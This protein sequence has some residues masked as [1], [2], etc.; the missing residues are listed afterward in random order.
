MQSSSRP[1][2]SSPSSTQAARCPPSRPRSDPKPLVVLAGET[3][4]GGKQNRIINVTVWL[5]AKKLT[6][7]P[8]T[9]LEH[10]RWDAGH[11]FAPGRYADLD[12]RAKVSATVDQRNH[13]RTNQHAV[14]NEISDKEQLA[15]R[16]SR[17]A[18]LHDLYET[19][20]VDLDGFVS[21]F[22]V[23]DGATGL[24]V[25]IGGKVVALDLF[26]SPQT[27]QRQWSRLIASAASALLDY[28]R[29]VAAGRL[30]KAEHRHPD[31]GA[32][33]RMLDRA[34]EAAA[35]AGIERSVGEGWDV[36]LATQ[37]LHGSALVHAGRVVHLALFRDEPPPKR[38]TPPTPEERP[39]TRPA[40]GPPA[41]SH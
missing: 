36:R 39:R 29:R 17:T 1:A 18:A 10:G 41:D 25:A 19:E 28:R 30:P 21:A 24:A 12:F 27:L 16:R 6:P 35:G 23:P 26:D 31:P 20:V 15:G 9:C 11:S 40:D 38:P 2:L 7:I 3:I 8:V 14:W 33:D 5:P 4:V 32:L 13:Y 22:A 34:K 37:K